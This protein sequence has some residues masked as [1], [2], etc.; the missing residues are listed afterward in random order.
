MHRKTKRLKVNFSEDIDVHHVKEIFPGERYVG[1]LARMIAQAKAASRD[2][3]LQSDGVATSHC[4][5]RPVYK[6]KSIS[7]AER[8][9]VEK[10]NGTR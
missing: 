4:L 8:S 1:D 7:L 2:E 10:G 5:S 9:H 3:F 6:L